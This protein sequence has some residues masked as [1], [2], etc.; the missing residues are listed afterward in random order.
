[1][2]L[3]VGFVVMSGTWVYGNTQIQTYTGREYNLVDMEKKEYGI[4]SSKGLTANVSQKIKKDVLRDTIIVEF[5]A[6]GALLF[7]M[8]GKRKKKF[9]SNKES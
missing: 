3:T 4:F 1:M 2:I 9:N 8:T 7:L 6:T 5:I